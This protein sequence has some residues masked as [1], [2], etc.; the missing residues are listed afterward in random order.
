MAKRKAAPSK[1]SP[2]GAARKRGAGSRDRGPV[3]VPKVLEPIVAAVSRR[4]GVTI[5]P[6]WGSSSVA[7][8]VGGKIFVM[9]IDD[10]LVMKLPKVR[11]DELVAARAGTRFDPRRD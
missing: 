1:A 10:T 5:E 3:V 7:L 4:P 9:L 6:G 11:V 8:K 2:T